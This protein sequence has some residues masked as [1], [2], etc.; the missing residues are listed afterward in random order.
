MPVK[1]SYVREAVA[2]EAPTLLHSLAG[3]SW[4]AHK[5][6]SSLPVELGKDDS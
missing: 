6:P 5:L 4:C 3:P 2:R 1:Q